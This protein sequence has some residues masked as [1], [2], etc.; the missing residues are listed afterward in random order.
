MYERRSADDAAEH[1]VV[2]VE[3]LR[4]RVDDDVRAVLERTEVDRTGEGGVDDERDA[5]SPS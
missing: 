1:V 5:R 2:P 3:V 4:R